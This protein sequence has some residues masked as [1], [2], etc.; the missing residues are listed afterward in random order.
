MKV[1]IKT[2]KCKQCGH[3]WT[4]RSADVRMCPKCKSVRFDKER[5]Q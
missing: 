1:K 3:T 4:P 2:I 5:T